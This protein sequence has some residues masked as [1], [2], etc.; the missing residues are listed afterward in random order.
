MMPVIRVGESTWERL[1]RWA[2]PLE[3]SPD[4]VLRR[5][6]DLAD[7]HVNCQSTSPSQP[8]ERNTL[9]TGSAGRLPRGVRVPQHAYRKPILEALYELGGKGRI[10]EVLDIVGR[11]MA[12]L[13]GEADYQPLPSGGDI[14]WRNSAQW[15]RKTLVQEGLLRDDSDR[16]VWELSEQGVKA[17]EGDGNLHASLGA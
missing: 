11:K 12:G 5:V 9:E 1:K 6:L 17:V 8:V 2:V 3:D 10:N 14:R 16:G 15:A 7:Q 4:D 13:L